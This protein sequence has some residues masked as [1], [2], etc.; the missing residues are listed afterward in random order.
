[1][2]ILRAEIPNIFYEV[3]TVSEIYYSFYYAIKYECINDRTVWADVAL[4]PSATRNLSIY[5]ICIVLA[6]HVF[7]VVV[8]VISRVAN[9]L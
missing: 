4:P 7:E 5:N 8:I 3:I 9:L 1:M 2:A 6:L